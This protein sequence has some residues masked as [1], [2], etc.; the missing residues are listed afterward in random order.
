MKTKLLLLI[1]F[2]LFIN[3]NAQINFQEHIIVN[4][5]Y[6]VDG[7]ISVFSA[8][9]DNDGDMDII[10]ASFGDNKIAWYENIDGL[11]N[12]G[13]QK[14]ITTETS[15]PKSV[16]A[17]D[18]DGDG[19]I[20]VLSASEGD[21]KIA[22]YENTDG[23]GNFGTQQIISTNS[24]GPIS[25]YVNDIDG[26]GH[27]D[28]V[29]AS[30]GDNTIA[31]YKNTNGLGNF[32]SQQIIST[33]A[34]RPESVFV[35]DINGDGNLD[36]LSA[37]LFDNKLAWYENTD[38]LGS[39]GTQQIISTSAS[40][41][42]SIYASDIDGDTDLDVLSTSQNDEKIAWYENTDG[43][44]SFGS[45]QVISTNAINA[46]SL[47]TTD[48]D[49]DGDMD[50]VSASWGDDKIAWYENTDGLGSFGLE[51]IITTNA[52]YAIS[53]FASDIN[54]DGHV[55][56]LSAS[57]LDDKI[58]WYDNTDGLGNYGNQQNIVVGN[59]EP[60]SIYTTDID[61]DGDLDMLS[62]FTANNIIAWYENTDG[63]G[64]FGNQQII[65][66]NADGANS[67]FAGDIDGDGDMDVV[68][69]S[70]T[71]DIIAWYENMDGLGGFGN[72][73]IIS[74]S[75][76]NPNSI[77]VSDIDGDFDMDVVASS[78][79][80]NKIVWFE[81]TN[82]LGNFGLE[83]IITTD[84]YSPTSVFVSDIDG[85]NDMDVLYASFGDSKIAWSE[86][87]D[88]L[89]SFSPQQI[90]TTNAIQ[91]GSVYAID[92]DSDGDNDVLSASSN[93]GKIALYKNTDGFGGFSSQQ[94]IY[95]DT[96]S[97]NAHSVI[98]SDIDG[99]GDVDVVA[100]FSVNSMAW[101]ENTNGLGSFSSP[102][103]I[104]TGLN[105][106]PIISPADL[107]GDG[108]IDILASSFND[109]TITWYEN[110]EALSIKE[111]KLSNSIVYPNPTTGILNI[112]SNF[113]VLKLEVFNNTGQIVLSNSNKTQINTSTLGS[114]LYF[115]QIEDIN[116]VTE[117]KKI[118]KE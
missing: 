96:N 25:I 13:L 52:D 114:G 113:Q 27:M 21:D 40:G 78:I 90:I 44:G 93:D 67:V 5:A 118:I 35:A 95:T 105:N 109:D 32:G 43:L 64:S 108:D 24:D 14:I 51:N 60:S 10:S 116:G 81:N 11:G 2:P 102:Q 15:G 115:I 74:T 45:Q 97:Y 107:D 66:S 106:A 17:A 63:L 26:D 34:N 46:S 75:S 104:S 86:N 8:D 68:S 1:S 70:K 72:Q 84:V 88:G 73:Q 69:S 37:S 31:W 111:T 49:G 20:D 101:F 76:N 94:I 16:F 53:V 83:N 4:N 98:P 39:F 58:S 85:D 54:G 110:T 50:V 91:V 100:T 28:V 103:Y 89:G 42:T 18:I 87:T 56:L 77:F 47:I 6:S 55:D 62:A 61:G 79:I 19:N 23:L 117:I 112:K 65:T 33:S 12:Y 29:Y 38:G 57:R 30:T 3:V 92:I 80:D 7:A 9:I 82:G 36:I 41:P 59:D 22:W 71:D 99:D 48:I